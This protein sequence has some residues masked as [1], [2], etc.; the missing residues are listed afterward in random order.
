MAEE[1]ALHNDC[2]QKFN[3]KLYDK[4]FSQENISSKHKAISIDGE[5]YYGYFLEKDRSS[6]LFQQNF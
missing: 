3:N 1:F 2:I 6:F 5:K 4:I